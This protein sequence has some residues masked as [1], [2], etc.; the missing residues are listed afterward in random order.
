MSNDLHLSITEARGGAAIATVTGV[1]DLHTAPAFHEQVTGVLATHPDLT[2]DLSGVA[3]CDSSGLNT[4]LRLHRHAQGLG[5]TLALADVPDQIGRML[6]L[7]GAG[8]V[9]TVF[10]TAAEAFRPGRSGS[11][12]SD[13]R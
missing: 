2:L 3:F 11:G 10:A 8:H 7:T 13:P 12:T 5:G 1:L 6:T 4:L 9:L